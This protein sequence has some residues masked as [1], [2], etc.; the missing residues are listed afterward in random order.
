MID[1]GSC[2]NVISE[3]AVAKLALFAEPHPT[4]YKLAWLNTQTDILISKPCKVPFSVGS[5]YRDL[6]SCDVVPMD[7]C[8][9]LLGCP[10]QFDRQ[11]THDGFNNTH[12]FM[13]ESKKIT[14][15]PSKDI[16]SSPDTLVPPASQPSAT[17]SNRPVLMLSQS[18]FEEELRGSDLLFILMASQPHSRET[19]TVPPNF[20]QLVAEFM[21]VFPDDLPAGLPPLRE[22]QHCID[23]TP[24]LPLPNRPHLE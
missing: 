18:K 16:A 13:F 5:S 23:L 11:T 4:P 14:L 7:A 24:H 1:S 3:E 12:S 2:T 17:V 15:L 10:W 22:I 6:V 19:L 20:E 21:D 9:L 8:H